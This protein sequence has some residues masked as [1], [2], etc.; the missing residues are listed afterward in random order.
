M[1]IEEIGLIITII[2]F[3]LSVAFNNYQMY[4]DRNKRWYVEIIINSNFQKIDGFFKK[5]LGEFKK[6]RKFLIDNYS[7]VS[8]SYLEQKAIR[9]RKL[10]KLKNS[11]HFEILPI[12]KSYDIKLAQL[13]ED[14]LMRFQDVY[15]ESIG[16]ENNKKTDEIIKELIERKRAFY[17]VL[18]NPIKA[19]FFQKI[20]TEIILRNILIL[21]FILF[22]VTIILK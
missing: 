13:L 10:D 19:S 14:E 5:T 2:I 17:N 21:L 16:I 18:Y 9:T 11:F 15:T 22:V 7:D 6:S 3:M 20:K 12:F 4:V 8:G 1:G